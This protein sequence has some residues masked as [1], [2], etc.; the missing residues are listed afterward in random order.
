VCTLYLAANPGITLFLCSHAR[1]GRVD[2]SLFEALRPATCSRDPEIL[3]NAQH[4]CTEIDRADR[5]RNDLTPPRPPHR[6]HRYNNVANSIEIIQIISRAYT[7]NIPSK[8][9]ICDVA[10]LHSALKICT[11]A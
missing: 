3:L 7:L 1:L 8:K 9:F 5:G 6:T 4:Y 10:S 11:R 2:N